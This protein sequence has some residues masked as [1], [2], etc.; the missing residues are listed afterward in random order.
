[1]KI[2]FITEDIF[3]ESVGGVEYHIYNMSQELAKLDNEI[4][5]FSL[6]IG[7]KSSYE[8]KLIFDNQKNSKIWLVK[9]IKKNFLFGLLKILN[10]KAK[11]SFGMAIGLLSKLLPNIYYKTLVNEVKKLDPEIVHQHDYLA[12]IVTSKI[13]SKKY[14]VIFTNHTGQYL[15]LEKSTIGRYIQKFLIKHFKTIIGPSRE[16]TPNTKNS[17]YVSNGVDINFF[18]GKKNKK[19]DK[20]FVFIC[21]RRWAPTKGIKYLAEAMSQLS[22]KAQSSSLFLFAGSDSDD[23]IWYK[24][25]IIKKLNKLPSH[26]YKLL[27]NLNQEE[28]RDVFLSSDVTIIPS[29]MEA[30]SLAAME[31]MA[32]GLPVISTNVGG[33]PEIITH[34][35]TGWLVNSKNSKEIVSIIEKIVDEKYD[36]FKMGESAN[37]YVNQNKS[38]QS[39]AIKVEKIYKDSLQHE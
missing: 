13:L 14:P 30:T 33:M 26:L 24:D 9:I 12:N 36:L 34:N 4:F 28:L 27:G 23:Y 17:H 7:S 38:W 2:A 10:Q 11:G 20:K 21:A 32:C 1:M 18:K 6:L 15:Y 3:G 22:E 39:I 19:L 16:L 31:G 5:I 29:V 37:Q 25:E 8:K 35:S